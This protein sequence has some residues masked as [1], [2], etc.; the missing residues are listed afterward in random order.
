MQDS[1]R[2]RHKSDPSLPAARLCPSGLGSL[3]A[4]ESLFPVPSFIVIGPVAPE[5]GALG[6]HLTGHLGGVALLFTAPSGGF[7]EHRP[8]NERCDQ[9]GE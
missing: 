4:L 7:S 8:N 9:D 3:D 6:D 5:G 1:L 2:L